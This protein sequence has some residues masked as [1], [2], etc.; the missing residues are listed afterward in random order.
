MP[1]L[2]NYIHILSIIV[3]IIFLLNFPVFIKIFSQSNFL[4]TNTGAKVSTA[5]RAFTGVLLF[6]GGWYVAKGRNWARITLGIGWIFN[7]IIFLI[8]PVLA[9]FNYNF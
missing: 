2:A 8:L 9:D 3:G 4:E 6:L 5:I 7:L 1:K